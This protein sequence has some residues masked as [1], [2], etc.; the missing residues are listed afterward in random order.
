LPG[1]VTQIKEIAMECM[2]IAKGLGIATFLIG[3]VTK[4]GELAGPR[5]LEHI[6]DTVLEFEGDRQHGYRMLRSIKNRFGPTDEVALFQMASEGLKEVEH[7]S[8]MF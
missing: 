4:S 7:P 2:H 8:E 6:V 3:H 1:S 5:V